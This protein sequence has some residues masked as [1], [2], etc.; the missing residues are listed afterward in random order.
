MSLG[1][2]AMV[3]YRSLDFERQL[4]GPD[5]HVLD[6]IQVAE[7]ALLFEVWPLEWTFNRRSWLWPTVGPGAR[8]TITGERGVGL[9]LHGRVAVATLAP[10]LA[11]TME[12]AGGIEFSRGLRYRYPLIGATA[13]PEWTR[14]PVFGVSLGIDWIPL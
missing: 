1:T 14:G 13:A 10:R 9:L 7:G 2:R 4:V 3:G 11:L 8:F 5:G 12:L 6:A